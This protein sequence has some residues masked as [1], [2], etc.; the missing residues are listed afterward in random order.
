MACAQFIINLRYALMS[1]SL[2][3]KADKSLSGI[4]RWL[5]GFGVTDEIFV[6]AMGNIGEVS[7]QYMYGLIALPVAGWSLGT[8]I[9]AAAGKILP[10]IVISALSIAIYGM[11]LAI[12]IPPAKKTRALQWRR[13]LRL[14]LAVVSSGCLFLI[15]YPGIFHNNLHRSF[16]RDNGGSHACEK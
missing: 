9:G 8:L 7:R 16:R 14:F 3:Q 13:Y 5:V 2:S 11:F 10:E 1:I 6:M 15:R 12:I 4:H